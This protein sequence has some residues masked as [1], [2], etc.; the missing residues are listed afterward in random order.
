MPANQLKNRSSAGDGIVKSAFD[1]LM[2][3]LE[4]VELYLPGEAKGVGIHVPETVDI[5]EIRRHLLPTQAIFRTTFG[6]SRG[7]VQDGEA[8]KRS[9][10]GDRVYLTIVRRPDAVIRTL[11]P[12]PL[13]SDR[14]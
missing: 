3:G 11:R 10:D 4:D 14:K 2:R 8:G 1:K 13:R 12:A 7:A 5:K 9:P 6:F